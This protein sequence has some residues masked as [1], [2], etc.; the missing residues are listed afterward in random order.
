[1][2]KGARIRE[3][4]RREQ[5]VE[6][7][8]E[9]L[10]E[11]VGNAESG[12][13]LARVVEE[14][15]EL[16]GP[17]VLNRIDSD[18]GLPHGAPY[19]VALKRM[20]RLAPRDPQAAWQAYS[21][22]IAAV[23]EAVAALE[24]ALEK[25]TAL[26]EEGQYEEAIDHGEALIVHAQHAGLGVL[27]AETHGRLA[28]AY[29]STEGGDKVENIDKAIGHAEGAVA[30]TPQP[31][32]AGPMMNLAVYIDMRL[33]GDPTQNYETGVAILREALEEAEHAGD[34]KVT[35]T[36]EMNL[37]RTVQMR[38]RGEKVDNLLEA[39][40]LCLHSLRYRTLERD[41]VD[42][43]HSQLNLGGIQNDLI[44][45]GAASIEDAE[46][47]LV[48][49]VKAD[50]EIGEQWLVGVAYSSLGAVHRDAAARIQRETE[51]IQVGPG[52]AAPPQGEEARYLTLARENLQKGLDLLDAVRNRDVVG[53]TLADLA[54]VADRFEDDDEAVALYRAAVAHVDP[55]LEPAVARDAGGRLG[56][57]LGS[58]GDW[59]DAAAAFLKAVEGAEL[60]FHARLD[61]SDRIQEGAR[62]GNLSRW[63]PYAIA[64]DGDLEKALLVLENGRTRELRRRLGTGIGEDQLD[65]LPAEARHDYES[66]QA[67][68]AALPIG[69]DSHEAAHELQR[70]ISAIRELPG[71]ESFGTGLGISDISGGVEEDCPL[72][73]VDPT[74]YG[75]LLLLAQLIDG[76]VHLEARFLEELTSFDV[77]MRTALGD[78]ERLLREP[79]N[80][81][82]EPAAYLAALSNPEADPE[83]L[84]RALDYLCNALG[85]LMGRPI[86]EFVEGI[87][88]SKLTLVPCGPLAFAPMHAFNW[89]EG[90][91]QVTL[92]ERFDLRSSPSA[93]LQS[94]SIQRAAERSGRDLSLVGLGDPDL[95]DP[96]KDLPAAG[97]E[98][99]EIAELFAHHS[100]KCAYRADA[101][102]TFLRENAPS[103]THLHLA[104]HGSGSLFSMEGEDAP[105]LYLADRVVADAELVTLGLGADLTVISAC[106]TAVSSLNHQPHEAFSLGVAFLAAGSTVAVASLWTV[107]DFASAILMTRFYTEMLVSDE[108]PA[109]ALRNAQ[110]WL[111][112][113]DESG[114]KEFLVRHPQ[115]EAAFRRRMGEGDPPGRRGESTS[116]SV[117]NA[118]PDRPYSSL[119]F[120]APFI[121]FGAG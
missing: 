68:L 61:T 24:P 4:R 99:E 64:R 27:V 55:R 96:R 77:F 28:A 110:L 1:M 118:D 66:A 33:K 41:A 90:G 51:R 106:E 10:F 93:T 38:Q 107:D 14:K 84:G 114:E 69:A 9:A 95:G 5:A 70:V 115:L 43:A 31:F 23:E 62:A 88:F 13:E 59:G 12:D 100:G 7:G 73:F 21:E 60:A 108:S 42:W 19:F 79:E 104:C 71:Q 112:D 102:S 50:G 35:A 37:A 8:V 45:L 65:P 16:F 63:A 40:D 2:G 78:Y 54:E 30:A 117:T 113:L 34:P 17:E 120:W 98:V 25:L 22:S 80:A 97:A 58:R 39:R 6:A 72:L 116:T 29:R 92:L 103:A 91:E 15:P 119:E 11:A 26:L 85:E 49:L 47:P 74:P 53:R 75:T 18:A 56:D 105:Q 81:E 121:C 20:L 101:T 48:E 46:A 87:G 44:P 3:E 109:R 57:L 89:E 52:R 32:R 111:R 94:A 36:V 76:E 83:H 67:G 86:A 82:Q